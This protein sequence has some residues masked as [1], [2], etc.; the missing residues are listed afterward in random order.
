MAAG[1]SLETAAELAGVPFEEASLWAKERAAEAPQDAIALH[2]ASHWA[3]T[4]GLAAL[5]RMANSIVVTVERDLFGVERKSTRDGPN[6]FDAAK[7][8]TR[9]GLEARKVA[10]ATASVGKPPERSASGASAKKIASLQVQLDLFDGAGPWQGLTD[11]QTDTPQEEQQT[12]GGRAASAPVR[13]T[14]DEEK[15]DGAEGSDPGGA[16]LPLDDHAGEEGGAGSGADSWTGH[17]VPEV[18]DGGD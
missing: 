12:D 1:H 18:Q 15:A 2:L 13:E 9:F 14:G 5:G 3:L 17:D 11:A 16:A 7:E 4:I 8:L 10:L 6:A